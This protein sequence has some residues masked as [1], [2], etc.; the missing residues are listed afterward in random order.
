MKGIVSYGG[1]LPLKRINRDIIFKGMGWLHQATYMKGEKCVANFDEDSITMAVAAAM[2]CLEGH[3]RDYLDGLYLATTTSPFKERRCADIIGTTLDLKSQIRTADFTDS[4]SAGTSALI[5]AIDCIGA[6]SA[7]SILLCASDVR[8]G[9]PGSSQELSFSDGAASLLLGKEGVIASCEGSYSVSYDFPDHWRTEGDKTDRS[10][11]DR[12]GREEGYRKFIPEAISGLLSKC[13]LYPKDIAKVI[14]PGMYPRDHASLCKRMG[15]ES[16]QI[17]DHLMGVMGN[18]GTAYPL[19]ILISALEASKPGDKVIVAGFGN[20]SDAVLFQVTEEIEKVKGQKKG[21]KRY[22]ES[23]RQLTSYEK[24]LA[25][26]NLISPEGGIRGEAIAYTALSLIWRDRREILGLCGTRCKK[27]GTP[28]YPAQRV[29]V[30]PDCG[31]IDEMQPYRFSDKKGEVFSFTADLLAFTPDPPGI[32][33]V[34]DF[35]G[36]GRYWFDVT[37]CDLE[38]MEIGMPV[39]MSFRRRYVDEKGGIVG[40]FWKTVPLRF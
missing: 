36:G 6:G 40:Y 8:V 34:I 37:D 17:Q 24:Y 4:T 21:I 18:T 38:S 19:M 29:C 11:E 15:F 10:W 26:R 33:A 30:N 9:K 16:D 13:N 12:F 5:A 3:D 1:Y 35:D 2:N 20:G 27:C 14:F 28:Q 23:K 7:N 32:Y 31:A 39:E 22:L 25:F